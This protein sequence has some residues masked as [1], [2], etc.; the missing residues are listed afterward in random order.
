[1]FYI[2]DGDY[3]GLADLSKPPR[4]MKSNDFIHLH[5]HS[6]FSL[7]DGNCRIDGLCQRAKELEMDSLALTDHG[8]LFGAV[9]FY[10]AAKKHGI[11]PI[12]GME[13]YLAPGS[14]RERQKVKTGKNS[15]HITLLAKDGTGFDNLIKLTSAAYTEG[16]TTAPGW[17]RKS[18]TNGVKA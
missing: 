18:L 12:V 14:R 3:D 8:N 17:T 15:Y 10:K 16:F 7:L 5:V 4:I 1:M 9:S 2:S 13:G 6:D 11:K